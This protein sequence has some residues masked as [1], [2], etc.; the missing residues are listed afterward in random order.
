MTATASG[1][2]GVELPLQPRSVG[3]LTRELMKRTH[4]MYASTAGERAG[5]DESRCGCAAVRARVRAPA[6]KPSLLSC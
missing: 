4:D 2:D 3:A 5:L 6:A 1:G